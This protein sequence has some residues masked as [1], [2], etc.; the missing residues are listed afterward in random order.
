M[1]KAD[2][3]LIAVIVAVVGVLSIFL[4]GINSNTGSFV[5]VEVNGEITETLPLDED[6]TIEIKT[7]NNGKNILEIKNKTARVVEANCPEKICKKHHAIKR[8]GESIVCLPHKVVIT[9]RDNSDKNEID[10]VV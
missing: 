10:A 8:N 9:V 2:F 1:K 6:K 7:A 4:Y 5:T 3:I